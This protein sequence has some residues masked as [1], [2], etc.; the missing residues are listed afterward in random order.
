[1]NFGSQEHAEQILDLCQ[2]QIATGD[3]NI[4]ED[5]PDWE[6]LS[7]GSFRDVYLH[8]PTQI[9]YK[10]QSWRGDDLD[11][12]G[13]EQ[14]H[15]NS[16]ALRMLIWCHVYI[17]RTALFWVDG[18]DVLAM[19][20]IVP[21]GQKNNYTDARQELFDKGGL[22]D[23]HAGNYFFVGDYIV[24]VDLGSPT[25]QPNGARRPADRRLIYGS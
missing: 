9:V 25:H 11:D 2:Q 12:M 15:K 3:W 6:Y 14:E 7:S 13:N 17:P 19:E 20:Y 24:P 4:I 5:H 21:A 10:F 23:M 18:I 16:V 22:G 1:M 8:V